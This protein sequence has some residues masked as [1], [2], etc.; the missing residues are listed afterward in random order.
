MKLRKTRY[1]NLGYDYRGKLL[2][3]SISPLI[4]GNKKYLEI[5]HGL[6]SIL[7]QML[8]SVKFIR[9]NNNIMVDED[10]DFIN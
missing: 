10:E 9:K 3:N 7:G 6:E 2:K 4:F 1:K 8:Y 5:L